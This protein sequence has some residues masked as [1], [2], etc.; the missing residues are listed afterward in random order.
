MSFYSCAVTRLLGIPTKLWWPVLADA[1]EALARLD[2]IG[3]TMKNYELLLQ[4]LQRR[5]ALRSSSLEGTYTTAKQLLLFEID[6][7]QP[8]SAQDSLG[9][10]DIIFD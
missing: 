9:V 2:G 1:R 6:P 10:I 3:K 8:T 4:P 7:K 5:E